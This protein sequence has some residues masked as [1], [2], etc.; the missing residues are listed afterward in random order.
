M[1]SFSRI[2]IFDTKGVEY[3]FVIGYLIILVVF[4]KISARQVKPLKL[5]RELAGSFSASLL[6]IPLGVFH[7]RNHTWTHLGA[8]GV[9]R[10]G[11]DDMLQHIT[12]EVKFDRLRAPGETINKGD[13]LSEIQRDGKKLRIFSPISGE[14]LDTNSMLAENPEIL[15][16]DPYEKGWIYKIRPSAWKSETGSYYLAEEAV[17]WSAKEFDRFK[18][19]LAASMKTHTPVPSM[20]MLQDGGELRDHTLSQLPD[21]VWQD[22]QQDFLNLP[23]ET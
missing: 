5:A 4:W 17:S 1:E 6:K 12:G 8:S 9:A 23:A 14:I 2:D 7:S 22:F 20:V 19:F 10:V 15:N 11:M 3:L 13:V 16:E 21:G 18:D